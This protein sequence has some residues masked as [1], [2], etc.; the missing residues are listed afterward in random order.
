MPDLV[1]D[2]PCFPTPRGPL[3]RWHQLYGSAAGARAGRGRGAR[4]AAPGC[5]RRAGQP[6][7]GAP[8]RRTASSSPR[9][10][11]PAEPA[12]LGGAALRPV[13]AASGHHLRAPADP[14]RAAAVAPRHPA[15]DR[16]HAAAAPAA[17]QPTSPAAASRSRSATRWRSTHS[18]PAWSRPAMQASQPGR[19]PRRVRAA[20]LAARR[21]SDGHRC[22]AAH[23]PVR[24]PDRGDPPLRS[25][26]PALARHAAERA[27]AAGARDPARRRCGARVPAPLARALR[28]RP[29]AQP[30]LSRRQRGPRAARHRVLAAAVPRRDGDAVRLPARRCRARRHRRA[31]AGRCRRSWEAIGHALRGPAPRPRATAAAAGRAVPRARGGALPR[32][33]H[34]PRVEISNFKAEERRAGA[35][36]NFPTA[37]PREFRLD[38]RAEQPLAPLEAFLAASPAACCWPRTRRAGARCSPA[39][40]ARGPARRE[41]RGLAGLP[42]LGRAP[43]AD[44]RRRNSPA[45]RCRAA[46]RAAVRIAALRHARPA[47]AP[48]PAHCLRSERDPARP[49]D[50]DRRGARRARGIRRRSL[51]RAADHGRR[52]PARRVPGA[53]IPGWRPAV[54]AGAFAAVHQPLHRRRARD[55]AAAQAR[56]GPVGAGRAGVPRNACATSRPN[57]ST[58]TRSARRARA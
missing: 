25:A 10:P 36:V 8:P 33:A 21:V 12:R 27:A 1:Q 40:C 3:V 14:G 20:R 53:R 49:A 51:R 52:R 22:T 24:R 46:G 5:R 39:C 16:R 18:A 17:V 38:A 26:D 37:A 15:R 30:D 54:R 45:S 58:S 44:G 41:V 32:I 19:G 56:L 42:R 34:F 9:R 6:Q 50:P 57:C 13:L 23:R 2:I 35:I 43:G 7:P 47:G 4:Y 55:R 48:A 11:A 29:D 31:R 28:G